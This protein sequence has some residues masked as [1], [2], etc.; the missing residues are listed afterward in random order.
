MKNK[1]IKPWRSALAT[2]L[3]FG[4]F[5][6][7]LVSGI[8]ITKV[9]NTVKT[10]AKENPVKASVAAVTGSAPIIF[11]AAVGLVK[12]GQAL[13]TLSVRTSVDKISKG[14]IKSYLNS[15]IE[16]FENSGKDVGDKKLFV[17]NETVKNEADPYVL[18]LVVSTVNMVFAKEPFLKEAL[19]VKL[20]RENCTFK[21]D[22][23]E[24]FTVKDSFCEINSFPSRNTSNSYVLKINKMYGKSLY[25]VKKAAKRFQSPQ[26]EIVWEIGNFFDI[27]LIS[28]AQKLDKERVFFKHSK[29]VDPKLGKDNL[30]FREQM[31][32][33]CFPSPFA[34]L[35]ADHVL[36]TYQKD[37][38]FM[39]IFK[40]YM[41]S[42][43]KDF[44]GSKKMFDTS[45][46]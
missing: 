22:W 38:V 42:L 26:R 31:I 2:A 23:G 27:C 12:L 41:D 33:R 15:E 8:E 20:Q 25:Q 10:F 40:K 9:K 7:Q 29:S 11:V 16:E 28:D 4:I 19:E 39:Q 13:G 30:Q 44:K 14:E 32:A 1:L 43:K 34:D 18:A 24:K 37:D 36:G 5:G 45:S 3:S 46:L 35:L 21:I 6:T 17:V